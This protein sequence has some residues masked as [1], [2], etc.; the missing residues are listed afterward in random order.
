VCTNPA[1]PG[2]DGELDAYFNRRDFAAAAPSDSARLTGQ[3]EAAC[4]TDAQGAVLRIK[5]L[6]GQN[7]QQ[8]TDF[9]DAGLIH[10]TGYDW[11]LHRRDV[12][13]AQGTILRLIDAETQTWL[14]AH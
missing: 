9:L 11:G 3:I 13:L 14:H 7:Q 6:P 2:G 10:G 1:A 12:A 5:V 4:R 8:I